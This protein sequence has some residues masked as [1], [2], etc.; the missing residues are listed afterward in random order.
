MHL[1]E[2]KKSF[3][4]F[5]TLILYLNYKHQFLPDLGFDAKSTG[6]VDLQLSV[7]LTQTMGKFN[8]SATP[9]KTSIYQ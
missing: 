7:I 6:W 9:C 4:K 3:I 5:A 1:C 8:M 2:R